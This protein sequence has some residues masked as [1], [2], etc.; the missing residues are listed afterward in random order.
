MASQAKGVGLGRCGTAAPLLPPPFR[1]IALNTRLKPLPLTTYNSQMLTQFGELTFQ[2]CNSLK[3]MKFAWE[4]GLNGTRQARLIIRST[5][6]DRS[7]GDFAVP[8]G[9]AGV[10]RIAL[11][12]VADIREAYDECL[13]PDATELGHRVHMQDLL[14]GLHAELIASSESKTK[15]K[16]ISIRWSAILM[17]GNWGVDW[18]DGFCYELRCKVLKIKPYSKRQSGMYRIALLR[19]VVN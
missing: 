8:L 12:R 7:R 5:K 18:H 9:V 16:Y 15:G 1:F 6:L 3:P 4:T 13:M 10:V 11:N 19:C 17:T 14:D 2:L